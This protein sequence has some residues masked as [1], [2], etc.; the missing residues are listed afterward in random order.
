LP[1]WYPKRLRTIV[2]VEQVEFGA[3]SRHRQQ[4]EIRLH[5]RGWHRQQ[6][7]GIG[8]QEVVPRALGLSI[9][10]QR[11]EHVDVTLVDKYQLPRGV[12]QI[13]LFVPGAGQGAQ[14]RVQ[15]VVTGII[16]SKSTSHNVH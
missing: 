15:V 6:L 9:L 3:H 8:A 11:Q 5:R 14:V 2:V 4:G 13:T 7:A 16:H 1:A 12:G 10:A